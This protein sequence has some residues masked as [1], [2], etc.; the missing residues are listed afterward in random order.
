MGKV[1]E[2]PSNDHFGV[3]ADVWNLL[4]EEFK[5][6]RSRQTEYLR[7]YE[8]KF[9]VLHG[10]CVAAAFDTMTEA[11]AFGFSNFKE[12]TFLLQRC[13]VGDQ[14][15]GVSLPARFHV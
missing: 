12:N 7:K 15:Y 9:L 3:S 14:D 5:S 11:D 13:S 6:Y 4:V 2:I 1:K 10:K 8:G